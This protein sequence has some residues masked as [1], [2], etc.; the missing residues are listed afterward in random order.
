MVRFGWI[1][2][3]L[4]QIFVSYLQKDKDSEL[5]FRWKHCSI[6]QEPLQTPIVACGL[7]RL[8]SKDAVIEALLDRANMPET[9]QHISSLKV[10]FRM[11]NL[12]SSVKGTLDQI[13]SRNAHYMFLWLSYWVHRPFRH[14]SLYLVFS[15]EG[16]SR[17]QLGCRALLWQTW[18]MMRRRRP[19]KVQHKLKSTKKSICPKSSNVLHADI[20]SWSFVT[21]L[22]WVCNHIFFC[23]LERASGMVF[24]L[25]FLY[26]TWFSRKHYK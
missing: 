7:G 8:Y 23:A 13:S 24:S 16:N 15:K 11:A 10:S 4:F 21:C 9:A 5:S 22:W 3:C 20:L 18:R 2:R 6:T 12:S 25:H 19:W 1:G 26:K 14:L 17:F